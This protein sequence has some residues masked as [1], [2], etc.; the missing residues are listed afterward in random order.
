MEKRRFMKRNEGYSLTE[1]II[2]LAIVAILTAAAMVTISIIHNAKAKEASSTMED[3]LSELEANAKGKMCVVSGTNQPEYRFALAVYKDGGKYYI[4]KGY[5]LGGGKDLTRRDSYDFDNVENVGGGKGKTFSS[6]ITV[7]YKDATG[8]ERAITGLDDAPV[9][10]VFDRQ[11]MC[12]AG[13]GKFNFHRKNSSG[14][15]GT[16]TLNKNGSHSSNN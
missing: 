14:T 3:A 6:Y 1:M 12:I 10:I 7:T 13:D 15:I 5:Y 8:S 16:V 9:F 11:G 4:K 2:V